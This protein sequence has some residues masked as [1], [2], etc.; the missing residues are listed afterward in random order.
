[1]PPPP[2]PPNP[3]GVGAE[4]AQIKERAN[5]RRRD[6]ISNKIAGDFSFG[7][8]VKTPSCADKTT[9]GRGLVFQALETETPKFGGTNWKDAKMQPEEALKLKHEGRRMNSLEVSAS[10][11]I[12]ERL[13]MVARGR[14]EGGA[15][16]RGSG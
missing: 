13:R 14:G 6:K 1:M 5:A 9:V 3:P 12:N 4:A 8:L 15:H 7:P 16:S 2:Q 11:D 10:F